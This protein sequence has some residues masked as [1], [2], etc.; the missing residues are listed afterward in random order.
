MDWSGE[1]LMAVLAVNVGRYRVLVTACCS[2]DDLGLI[3]AIYLLEKLRALPPISD[4][5][6]RTFLVGRDPQW[7][8][9]FQLLDAGFELPKHPERAVD[10]RNAVGEL[11]IIEFLIQEKIAKGRSPHALAAKR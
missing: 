4:E 10:P 1:L 6:V 3:H 8:K 7:G 11:P 5:E 2:R 9:V